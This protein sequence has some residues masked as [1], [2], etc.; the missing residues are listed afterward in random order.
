[1]TKRL[2]ISPALPFRSRVLAA[3]R[4][5]RCVRVAS[6]LRRLAGRADEFERWRRSHRAR[7]RGALP[8]VAFLGTLRLPTGDEQ[9][10]PR[11][12]DPAF[13]FALSHTLSE[14]LSLGYNL[15][16]AWITLAD[17]SGIEDTESLFDWTVALGISA[18][19]RLGFFVEFYGLAGASV[20]S[21]PLNVLQIGATYLLTPRLQI[22]A[23]ASVGLSEIAP[24]W[25]VGV[26]ISFR[27]PRSKD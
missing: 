25:T 15:G 13:R 4:A 10:R 8:Q 14:R 3:H 11:R 26:G 1:M 22:D 9:L 16:L 24:D 19:E 2:L 6:R 18:A 27:F 12:A 5:Q 20:S 7:H 21:K 23:T 17:E